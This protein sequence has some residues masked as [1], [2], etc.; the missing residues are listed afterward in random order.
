MMR[1][2]A[3]EM[4]EVCCPPRVGRPV[5][6]DRRV[7][8]H[9]GDRLGALSLLDPCPCCDSTSTEVYFFRTSEDDEVYTLMSPEFFANG[10]VLV[11]LSNLSV[12]R[13]VARRTWE[14]YHDDYILQLLVHCATDNPSVVTLFQYLAGRIRLRTAF[15][16]LYFR[17]F[18]KAFSPTANQG[19]RAI[20]D[21]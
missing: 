20:R 6:P 8:I 7:F 15:R 17:A 12:G 10:D 4:V 14:G 21:W 11:I 13:F 9:V 18:R 16:H 3:Y 19:R 2:A 1:H 5:P